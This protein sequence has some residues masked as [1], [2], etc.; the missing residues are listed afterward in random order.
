[1]LASAAGAAEHVRI[2]QAWARPTVPGQPVGA[3]YFEIATERDANLVDLRSDAADLVQ[4]HTMTHDGGVM[5]MRQ[6]AQLKLIAH[7]PVRLTPGG[8]H[9]MLLDLKKP[10]RAG[11]SIALEL[12]LVDSAGRRQTV[13]TSVPVRTSA[14]SGR[15]Q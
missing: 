7:Q 15:D 9:V 5:R 11:E 4:I 8:L 6:V 10:L 1:M 2:R 13:R 14:P 3:A 12:T